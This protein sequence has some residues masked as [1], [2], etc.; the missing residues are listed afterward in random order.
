MDLEEEA[1]E[2]IIQEYILNKKQEESEI[3][4]I[5]LSATDTNNV[6]LYI[7]SPV[8]PCLFVASPPLD[9]APETIIHEYV[10]GGT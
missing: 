6:S 9:Y 8:C 10:R 4:A 5:L 3:T 1:L 2:A 7:P